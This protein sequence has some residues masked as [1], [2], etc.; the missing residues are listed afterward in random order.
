MPDLQVKVSKGV[1]EQAAHRLWL[2]YRSGEPCEPI[3]DLLAGGGLESAYAVQEINTQRRLNDGARL[4]GRKVG[5]TAA[6]TRKQYGVTEPDCGM[7]FT[8]MA[9]F[10]GAEVA[11]KRFIHPKVEGEIAFV[12][13]RDL[14]TESPS[15]AQV[16]QAVDFVV[17]AIEIV[18]SRVQNWDTRIL[19][20]VA[21][22]ASAAMFV[23]GTQPRL[24]RDLDLS[25]CALVME[26]RGDPVVTGAATNVMGNPLRSLRWVAGM[27]ARTGH[28]LKA[29]DTIMS[30][31]LGSMISAVAGDSFEARISGL[32]AVRVSFVKET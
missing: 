9:L 1:L 22:N 16:L 10:D 7:L 3:R 5:L 15:P 29:G 20:M 30:G 6:A 13:G 12:L 19:D 32:G 25:H 11:A 28:P 26:R 2:A 14:D 17:A 8:D 24:L 21:D 4:V 18:D 23:V 31:A 27:A